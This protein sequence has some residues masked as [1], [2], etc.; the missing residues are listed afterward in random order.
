MEYKI[1]PSM[2]INSIL[3]KAKSGD[4]LILEDG[5]YRE[6]IEIWVPNIYLK[7]KHPLKAILTNKDYYHK[8]MEN[9]NECNTF[10][11]FTLYVGADHVKIENLI[12]Q[13]EATPSDVYGQAVALHVD[14]SYFSCRNC[15]IKSAQDTLF[16]GPMPKDLLERYEGF[17]PEKRLKGT[18]TKQFYYNCTIEGDVDFIFG[19]ATAL[20]Q[21][22][23]LISLNRT[24]ME[25]TYVTAPSH[26]LEI[27][28][29]YLF[30][31]CSFI[32][33]QTPAY[34]ARPWRDYGCAAFIQCNM[35]THILPIGYNKWNNTER[36]KTARF[37]E[38]SVGINLNQRAAWAHVL[39]KKESEEYLS[40]YFTYIEL[41]KF[42]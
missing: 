28:Y 34:L 29:G 42:N 16:T 15:F 5:I 31:Q 21:Q 33:N 41:D 23:K 37:Y 17:Y 25:A 35:G 24:H 12:I 2:S 27:P 7:A 8:I 36:D 10:N 40:S 32:G 11:T 20:F 38:Y 26:P 4:V 13:N 9:Y 19:S 30:Y 6:K 1:F 18:P 3:S 14:G 22:C 39:T